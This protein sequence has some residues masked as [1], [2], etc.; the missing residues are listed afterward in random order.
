MFTA[1]CQPGTATHPIT[2]KCVGKRLNPHCR[3]IIKPLGYLEVEGLFHP[4][5]W[6]QSLR[7]HRNRS[8]QYVDLVAGD[9]SDTRDNGS[10]TFRGEKNPGLRL[11]HFHDRTLSSVLSV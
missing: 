1:S 9:H 2:H 8:S 11:I 6:K 10:S 3:A 5:P 7:H 4:G